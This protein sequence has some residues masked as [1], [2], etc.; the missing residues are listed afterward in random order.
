[1]KKVGRN[2]AF[3]KALAKSVPGLAL[4]IEH[5]LLGI[6]LSGWL[7]LV[8][9]PWLAGSGWAGPIENN[10]C[11]CPAWVSAI[12]MALFPNWMTMHSGMGG[13]AFFRPSGVSHWVGVWLVQER[14]SGVYFLGQGGSSVMMTSAKGLRAL[15]HW[16]F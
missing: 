6:S 2:R 7:C 16:N 5:G 14:I 10:K 3:M 8:Y 4:A 9:S 11:V 13:G 1:M 12:Y 15:G